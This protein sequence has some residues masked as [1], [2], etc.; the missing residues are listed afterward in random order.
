[1]TNDHVV[2]VTAASAIQAFRDAEDYQAHPPPD[3]F[4]VSVDWSWG[5]DSAGQ[6]AIREL[7]RQAVERSMP[8]LIASAVVKL[9]QDAEKKRVAAIKVLS[10]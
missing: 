4:G 9:R 7:I 5:R 10:E 8:D 1:M 6:I 3:K 2:L